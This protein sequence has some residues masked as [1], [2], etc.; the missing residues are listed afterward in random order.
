MENEKTKPTI[1]LKSMLVTFSD[2]FGGKCCLNPRLVLTAG[3][4]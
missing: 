3:S 4:G 1:Y 2:V